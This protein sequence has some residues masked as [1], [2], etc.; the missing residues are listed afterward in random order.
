MVSAASEYTKY[1]WGW[2]RCRFNIMWWK[3]FYRPTRWSNSP[4]MPVIPPGQWEYRD[5]TEKIQGKLSKSLQRFEWLKNKNRC[6]FR[7]LVP[8]LQLSTDPLSLSVERLSK[9]KRR[10]EI[11]RIPR[12]RHRASG[13]DKTSHTVL[14]AWTSVPLLNPHGR[15]VSQSHKHNLLC[16]LHSSL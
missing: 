9:I 15:S 3:S 13:T 16:L 8:V 1:L 11:Y 5:S 2:G 6:I 12:Q 4:A 7:W 14:N 10:S